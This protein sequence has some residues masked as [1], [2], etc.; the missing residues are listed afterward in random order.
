MV[1][2]EAPETTRPCVDICQPARKTAQRIDP[3]MLQESAILVGDQHP[4]IAGIDILRVDRQPPA[5]IVSGEG[6]KQR[7]R[8][9]EHDGGRILI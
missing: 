6:S 4:K 9:V 2:V 7:A 8:A 1:S 5:A 3:A